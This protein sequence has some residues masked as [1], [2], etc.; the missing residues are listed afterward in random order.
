MGSNSNKNSQIKILKPHAHL[1][2]TGMKSTKF[3]MNQMK[4]VEGVEETRFL[5][6]RANVCMGNTAVKNSLIK[7]PKP[8]AHLH[9]IGRKS[10]Y[11]RLSLS[12]SWRDPLKHFRDIRTSTYQMFRIEENTNRTTKFH[13]W[14]CNLTPLVRNICWKYCGKGGKL[15]LLSTIF[16]YLMLELMLDRDQIFS[17]R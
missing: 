2:I 10:T 15:L 9:I 17:S 3:Q 16:S 8:H 6:Y 4:D 13:K 12:R 11:S 14:T 1:C 5:T 7:N